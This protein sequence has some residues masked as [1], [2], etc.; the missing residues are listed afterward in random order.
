MLN[1]IPK[2]RT[3]P[4]ELGGLGSR[5]CACLSA[6]VIQYASDASRSLGL[7]LPELEPT[8]LTE[9]PLRES[10]GLSEEVVKDLQAE[11]P[12]RVGELV[13]FLTH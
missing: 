13:P 9:H 6:Q 12:D 2:S 7:G 3:G 4:G 1:Y 8:D 10:L 11:M 5:G